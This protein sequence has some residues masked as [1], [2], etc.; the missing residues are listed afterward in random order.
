MNTNR[1]KTAQLQEPF[2]R[3]STQLLPTK[4]PDEKKRL[5]LKHQP[6]GLYNMPF[7]R[8]SKI[9]FTQQ[10]MYFLFRWITFLFHCGNYMYFFRLTCPS[11]CDLWKHRHGGGSERGIMIIVLCAKSVN[12]VVHRTVLWGLPPATRSTCAFSSCDG[13]RSF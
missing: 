2:N 8:L 6:S 9:Y 4:V 13:R 3:L 7:E 5:C 1:S 12:T 10:I 11:S